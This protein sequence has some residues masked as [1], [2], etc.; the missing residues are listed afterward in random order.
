MNRASFSR[1]FTKT[2]AC[3]RRR[4]EGCKT[5]ASSLWP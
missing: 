2:V 4:V 3:S 5:P 1:E